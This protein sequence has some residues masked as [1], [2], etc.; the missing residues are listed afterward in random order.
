[1][2]IKPFYEQNSV[3]IQSHVSHKQ[4]SIPQSSACSATVSNIVGIVWVL[5]AAARAS[6]TGRE[7]HKVHEMMPLEDRSTEVE[8]D[9]HIKASSSNEDDPENEE[10]AGG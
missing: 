7:F 10:I 1:M 5:L 4:I 9:A 2:Q 6:E 3:L 8:P